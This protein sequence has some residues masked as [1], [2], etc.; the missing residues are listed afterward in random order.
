MSRILKIYPGISHSGFRCEK[1][2]R[3]EFR[4]TGPRCEIARAGDGLPFRVSILGSR[5]SHFRIFV[6]SVEGGPH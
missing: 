5:I 3:F 4:T 2:N 6:L 1:L